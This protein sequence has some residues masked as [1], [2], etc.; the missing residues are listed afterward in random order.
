MIKA[1]L[2]I[3]LKILYEKIF[4]DIFY[5]HYIEES[6]QQFILKISSLKKLLM[7]IKQ[8]SKLCE[9]K[10]IPEENIVKVESILKDFDIEILKNSFFV[11]DLL[12]IANFLDLATKY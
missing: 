10:K 3:G 6:E 12:I 9:D 7:A 8:T 11:N 1:L 5:K 2:I 4:P